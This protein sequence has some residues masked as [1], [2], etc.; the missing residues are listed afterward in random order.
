MA[1]ES[2]GGYNIEESFCTPYI[3]FDVWGALARPV[4]PIDKTKKIAP[5]ENGEVDDGYPW[6]KSLGV[7]DLLSNEL[8][9]MVIDNVLKLEDNDLVALGLTCQG[10]WELVVHRIQTFYVK[11]AGPWAGKKIV[12][13]GSWSTTVPPSFN[14]DDMVLKTQEES[15]CYSGKHNSR[16][17]FNWVEAEGKKLLTTKM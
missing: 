7:F 5:K 10:F 14:D 15:E 9:E 6:R 2:D 12:L 16:S 13:L 1:E 4:L 8:V 11:E 3:D 17:L